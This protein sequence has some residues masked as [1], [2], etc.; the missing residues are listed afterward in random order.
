[1]AKHTT[2]EAYYERLKNLAN[3]N[4][5]SIKESNIRNLGSLLDYKR[6][7][8]GIAY[9]IIKEN[10]HYYIKKAGIKQDPNVSDFAYIGG[11]GNI[12]DYQYKSLAEADKQRNML[13]NIIGEAK[14]LK[15]NKTKSKIVLTEGAKEEIDQAASK[16]PELDAATDVEKTAP[17][18]GAEMAAGIDAM[19]AGPDGTTDPMATD[20]TEEKPEGGDEENGGGN[21]LQ[22]KAAEVAEEIKTTDVSEDDLKWVLKRII[23][24]FA[25]TDADGNPTGENKM[26]KI[27][28]DTRDA[29]SK[30]ITEVIPPEEIEKVSDSVPQEKPGAGN[31]GP[32]GLPEG[33][34]AECGSIAEYM[35]SRGVETAEALMECGEEEVTNLISG[36][37]NAHNDGQN[38][39]DTDNVALIIKIVNPEMLNTLKNDYGHDDYA[40]KLEPI[41][42]GMNECSQEEGIVKLNELFGG[43][44]QMAKDAWGG[45]KSGANAVGSAIG[46][47]ATAVGQGVGDASR[48]VQKSYHTGEVAGEIKKLEAIANN[49]GAQANA[50]N[51]RLKKAGQPQVDL[52]SLITSLSNSIGKGN[53]ANYATTKAAKT[54]AG[55]NAVQEDIDPANVEVQPVGQA[56]EE[57]KVPE[58]KGKSLSAGKT[59]VKIMK[60]E[61]E[62]VGEEI[63]NDEVNFDDIE[64]NTDEIEDD[65]D[66]IEDDT[67]EKPF[68]KHG[69]KPLSFGKDSQSLGLGSIKPDGAP[70]T[71]KIE[72]DKSVEIT[73][74]ESE[75]RLRKYIRERLEVK[76]GLRKS[77]LN[78]SKKSLTLKKLDGVIDNQLKLYEGMVLK[79]KV[80]EVMGLEKIGINITGPEQVSAGFKGLDPKDT[81]NI[82]KLFQ[83][84]FKNILINPMMGAIGRAAKNA[85]PKEKYD[86]IQQYVD[87]NGGTL[88]IDKG[89]ERLVYASEDV[90]NK[91]V[92]S[93]LGGKNYGAIV[94]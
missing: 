62:P 9:G 45:V 82:D 23:D 52:T 61:D 1:M 19:P 33:Q 79:K 74:N 42:N 68:E 50:L 47:A 54:A 28:S 77:N 72:P 65:T 67:D 24:G 81:V 46:S 93:G 58:K 18:G 12:T 31:L 87:G 30:K 71:I 35:K 10:H 90:K 75:L 59:P 55:Q 80:N 88:R 89:T 57:V 44:G 15:P 2:R 83:K 36:Y 78:E 40:N 39:G 21:E 84:A 37:A 60:E 91:G 13:F 94:R 5:T 69:D 63:E 48:A 26:A 51:V 4:K 38:D 73:M 32:S 70:T 76:A 43:L 49:L 22:K 7:S 34:C 85:T 11:M 53:K 41:V 92:P 86:L 17:E 64:N 14:Q 25:P 56:I 27:D 8:D 66:E 3:V 20:D 6:A 29:V 16:V